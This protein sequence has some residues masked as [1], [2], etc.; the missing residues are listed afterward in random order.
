MEDEIPDSFIL[1]SVIFRLKNG[2][3]VGGELIDKLS[4][5]GGGCRRQGQL[6]R[7]EL[8][9]TTRHFGRCLRPFI[10]IST[11]KSNMA[12][13]EIFLLEKMIRNLETTMFRFHVKVWG[14]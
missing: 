9:K 13:L 6:R 11:L 5:M 8:I 10:S 3:F 2:S 4:G 12:A 7:R 14:V 1:G